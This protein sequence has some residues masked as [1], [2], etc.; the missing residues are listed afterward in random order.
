M[1]KAGL[2]SRQLRTEQRDPQKGSPATASHHRLQQNKAQEAKSTN[3]RRLQRQRRPE[4]RQQSKASD[5]MSPRMTALCEIGDMIPRKQNHAV[6][7]QGVAVVTTKPPKR[8]SA[9]LQIASIP[10]ISDR[11]TK[12]PVQAPTFTD[13]SAC[14]RVEAPI[15]QPIGKTSHRANTSPVEKSHLTMTMCRLR[16]KHL[17][18]GTLIP[19]HSAITVN[20][21]CVKQKS[22]NNCG[23]C[24]GKQGNIKP[25]L[26]YWTPRCQI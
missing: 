11:I 6:H 7:F 25:T 16:M 26:D 20:T 15:V 5:N 22:R 8:P 4:P 24:M 18:F 1:L 12:S 10:T 13:R 14:R 2:S 17:W 9:I 23:R 21:V 19:L 3:Q